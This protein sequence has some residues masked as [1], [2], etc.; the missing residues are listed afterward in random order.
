MF[1]PPGPVLLQSA[2]AGTLNHALALGGPPT[3]THI[4]RQSGVFKLSGYKDIKMGEGTVATLFSLISTLGTN[5][6]GILIEAMHRT[7]I[8]ERVSS[9]KR[10]KVKQQVSRKEYPHIR[11]LNETTGIAERVSSHKRV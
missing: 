8:A 6:S 11:E 4:T 9:H 1:A 5:A 10:F 2:K 7:G 3:S